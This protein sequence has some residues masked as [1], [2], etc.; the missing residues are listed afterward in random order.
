MEASQATKT[1]HEKLSA[2]D[3]L[4]P[5]HLSQNSL[6]SVSERSS[7]LQGEEEEVKGAGEV[8]HGIAQTNSLYRTMFIWARQFDKIYAKRSFVH[9]FVGEGMSEGF[10]GEAREDLESYMMDYQEVFTR[11]YG[12]SSEESDD[13]AIE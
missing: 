9:W 4:G 6:T 13:E 8:S 3:L 11:T 5:P 1:A 7:Y 2:K 10:Y 12:D